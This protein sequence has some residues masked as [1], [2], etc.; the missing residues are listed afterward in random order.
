MKNNY[1]FRLLWLGQSLANL[2][3]S[4]YILSLVSLVYTLTHSAILSSLVPVVRLSAMIIGGLLAPLLIEKFQSSRLLSF[5]LLGQTLLLIGLTLVSIA[6]NKISIWIWIFIALISLF[7]GWTLPTRN[8][9]VP[10][11]VSREELIRANSLLATSDQVILLTGWSLGGLLVNHFGSVPILWLTVSCFA[12][13]TVS[14]LFIRHTHSKDIV[15]EQRAPM[16]KT[17]VEGWNYLFTQ[18]DLKRITG[19]SILDYAASSVWAGAIILV[20]VDQVLHQDQAWWGWINASYFASSILGGLLVIKYA[21]FFKGRLVYTLF[22]GGIVMGTLTLLFATT[23]VP[24]IS[25]VLSLLMGLPQQIKQIAERTFLQ[26]RLSINMLP[27]VLAA[28][29]T[30]ASA[31]FSLSVLLMGWITDNYSVKIAYIVSSLFCALSAYIALGLKRQHKIAS[32]SLAS[33]ETIY[34]RDL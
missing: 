21:D 34:S 24:Y 32:N 19:M 5:S 3:D 1:S 26:T 33:D 8:A 9:L 27:K 11:L 30:M 2:A 17:I 7:D 25:L 12:I 29:Q 16:R 4:L 10:Q 28:H 23:S 14:L 20:F 13:S 22:I 18:K 15:K 6:N 31:T